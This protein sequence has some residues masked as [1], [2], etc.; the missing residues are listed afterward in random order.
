[1]GGG[2]ASLFVFCICVCVCLCCRRGLIL[3]RIGLDLRLNLRFDL[4]SL[5]LALVGLFGISLFVI[6]YG[7]IRTSLSTMNIYSSMRSTVIFYSSRAGM[8]R[9]PKQA[10]WSIRDR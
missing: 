8:L 3:D 1:M 2:L 7:A 10:V 5:R 4:L 6:L 9:S